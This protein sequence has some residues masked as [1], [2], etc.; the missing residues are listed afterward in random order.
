MKLRTAKITL[1]ALLLVA[2]VSGLACFF[3]GYMLL[4]IAERK[5]EALTPSV[6]VVEISNDTTDPELWGRNYPLQYDDYLK[7]ADMVQTTYGGSEAMP[8]VPTDED[9][10]DIVSKSK[11]D[12][13]PQLRRMWAGY[14]FSK[15]F[16]EERG[17][18]YMLTDQ[19]YTERQ[20][21]GQ[22]GTCINCHASTFVAM[23]ELGDGDLF[24]GFE[25]LNAMPYME[26]K[27]H[28]EHPVACIDCHDA[29]TMALRVTRPAFME[30]I[31]AAK[32]H[33]GIEDYDVNTMATRHEMR[34]YV[35]AQCH[36]EYYFKG[37]K[38][39]LT[40]PWANGLTVD[41][42]YEYYEETGF[43]DWTHAETGAPMLKAQ[44]PEFET[45]SQGIHARS[46]VTCSDCHMPYKRV[47]ATK[48]SDHHV[49]SPL[50]NVN[51]AC[52]TCHKYSDEELVARAE[53]IQTRHR[54]LVEITLD[55][56]VDLI[57][58]IKA[59][60]EA[61]A[62]DEQLSEA[63]QHQRKASFYVDYVEAENSSG[64]HAPQESARILGE[65]INA[66]RLG[67][68]ALAQALEGE[69]GAAE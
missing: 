1:G 8:N 30:G 55:A 7:T 24:V 38:K 32:A 27:E 52:G 12:T 16:R 45:W 64:F 51:N 5:H 50:L 18:A 62:T 36:V 47:G 13:V 15:D 37:D 69:S 53:S 11:L 28:L 46:G 65:S 29:D 60:K 61:G 3:A 42:A 66:T 31:A 21:V 68:V 43:K 9:P 67:Q 44:H 17:H 25:K 48:I 41:G 56:L 4:N 10:R 34:T 33:E 23:K 40:Y 19:L 58:D 54:R 22:P 39:R 6:R 2:L 63:Q 26:A 14:A 59:A 49:Q 35:C 20:K 57:D